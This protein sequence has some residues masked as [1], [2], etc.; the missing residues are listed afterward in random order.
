MALINHERRLPNG[1][2]I[3]GEPSPE[4]CRALVDSG[5]RTMVSMRAVGESPYSTA[6]Y[7]EKGIDL[8]HLPISG[9]ADFTET[10]LREFDQVQKNAKAPLVIFC[11]TGNRVGAALA[12][13]GFRYGKLSAESAL[14][15]GH[16]AGLTRLEGFV[17]QWL[18]Q[19]AE[20]TSR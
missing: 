10:F 2:L 4:Q 17:R 7:A 19:E 12:L 8:V 20:Q 5:Y 18:S 9:P 13:H 3:G 11:A 6:W 1:T 16:Q 14:E 15:L